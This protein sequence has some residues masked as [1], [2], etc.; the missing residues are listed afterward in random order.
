VDEPI[1]L[2][3]LLANLEKELIE[4]AIARARGNK[5]KAAKLLGLNRPRLYR[6]LVQLGLAEED[7][8]EDEASDKPDTE[9]G[10]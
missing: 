9:P 6:R 10:N 3:E 7:S 4:R 2:E 8:D 5:S 1:V